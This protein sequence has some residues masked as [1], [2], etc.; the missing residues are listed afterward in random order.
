[1][2]EGVCSSVYRYLGDFQLRCVRVKFLDLNINEYTFHCSGF[3]GAKYVHILIAIRVD[4]TI[5]IHVSGR[6][7][8][9]VVPIH[10][11]LYVVSGLANNTVIEI[12]PLVIHE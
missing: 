9:V 11:D 5:G 8:V 6:I 10:P 2:L 3:V 12:V 4:N 1:M 7:E